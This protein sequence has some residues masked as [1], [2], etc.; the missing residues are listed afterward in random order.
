MMMPG[1]AIGSTK[2]S[3]IDSFARKLLRAS[4][5]A[6]SVPRISAA[7]VAMLATMS[8]RRIASQISSRANAASNQCSV[9]PGGG[10]A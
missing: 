9:S 3:V 6:A 8:E 5:K 2:S 7:S 10:K 1:S 4:A